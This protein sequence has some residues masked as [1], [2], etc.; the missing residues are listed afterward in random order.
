[1]IMKFCIECNEI[2]DFDTEISDDGRFITI[3]CINCLHQEI[4]KKK[5]AEED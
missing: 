4:F 5:E 2:S 1:M 3:E